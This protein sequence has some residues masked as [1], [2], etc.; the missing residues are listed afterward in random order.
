MNNCIENSL[1]DITIYCESR[2]RKEKMN[3]YCNLKERNNEFAIYK[4][5]TR[6]SDISG[7]VTFYKDLREP[8]LNKQAVKYLV[9]PI[10]ITRLYGKYKDDFAKGIFKDKL[11]IE[12]G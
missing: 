8:K 3:V 9:R 2:T 6:V 1:H 5:G 7:E 4:I 10:Q 11:A 12:I